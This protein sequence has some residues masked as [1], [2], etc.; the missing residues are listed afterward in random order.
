MSNILLSEDKSGLFKSAGN[1]DSLK[2]RCL[3]TLK[4]ENAATKDLFRW[5]LYRS[6][7]ITID[8]A[9]ALQDVTEESST[10][11]PSESADPGEIGSDTFSTPCATGT[12]DLGE[13]TDAYSKGQR[14]RI[15]LCAVNSIPGSSDESRFAVP[16]ANGRALVSSIASEAWQ[17]LGEAAKAAGVRLSAGSSWRT[18]AHQEE[19]CRTDD[20]CPFGNYN[21]VAKPGTSNHQAGTAI[22][23]AEIYGATN[24]PSSGRTC[25]NPQTA[26]NPTYRWVSQNARS[27]GIK[28]YANEAWHWG[29]SE[30]C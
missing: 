29:T 6:D 25:A 27:F 14:I 10:P 7:V 21:D 8:E 2:K 26:D 18:M 4:N 19:L 9:I 1:G 15:R 20:K 28:N 13:R 17:K 5:R 16:G 22:D 3:E 11:A 24:G 23:I 30:A 12:E